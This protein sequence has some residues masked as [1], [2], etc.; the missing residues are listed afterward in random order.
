MIVKDDVTLN[1]KMHPELCRL[2]A[3]IV[4]EDKLFLQTFDDN[5][6]L[7]VPMSLS[8]GEQEE[9]TVCKKTCVVTKQTFVELPCIPE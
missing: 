3:S 2:T 9:K 7:L 5:D 6:N 8:L 4:D 1:L